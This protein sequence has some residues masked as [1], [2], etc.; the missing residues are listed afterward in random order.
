MLFCFA[1]EAV[2][3]SIHNVCFGSKIRKLGIPL[4]TLFFYIKAEFKNIHCTDIFSNEYQ[5]K[6]CPHDQT[7]SDTSAACLP[8]YLVQNKNRKRKN[9]TGLNDKMQAGSYLIL[10]ARSAIRM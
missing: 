8:L 1:S 9:C 3:T 5:R 7:H 4:K 6:I 2:L 10:V